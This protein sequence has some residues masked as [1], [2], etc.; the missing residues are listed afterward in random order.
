MGQH[1]PRS[2][3]GDVKLILCNAE[4]HGQLGITI[5]RK[6]VPHRGGELNHG[7]DRFQIVGVSEPHRDG[8]G[9]R[10]VCVYVQPM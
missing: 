3:N 10:V 2:A 5:Q 9:A 7:R 6:G 1:K 8:D 4:T